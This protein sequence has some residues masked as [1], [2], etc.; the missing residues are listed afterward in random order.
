MLSNIINYYHAENRCPCDVFIVQTQDN[1][2]KLLFVYSSFSHVVPIVEISGT[3]AEREFSSA[4]DS[5]CSAFCILTNSV[6]SLICPSVTD[7]CCLFPSAHF[8]CCSSFSFLFPHFI[9][10]EFVCVHVCSKTAA[11]ADGNKRS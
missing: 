1:N 7:Y 5:S 9:Y 11:M 8:S 4:S 2:I 10:I 6:W 3:T